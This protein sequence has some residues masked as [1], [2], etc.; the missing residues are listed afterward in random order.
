VPETSYFHQHA[1]RDLDT[2]I[3]AGF[4]AL[5]DD[6]AASAVYTQLLTLA[7]ERSTLLR[8]IR[9]RELRNGAALALQNLARHHQQFLAPPDTWPGGVGSVHELVHSLAQHLLARYPVPALLASAWL[10]DGADGH[11]AQRWFVAHAAGRRFRDI[12]DMPLQLTRRMEHILLTSPPHLPLRAALRRAE[13]LGLDAPPALV[14]T[15]L[16]SELAQD[17]GE[18]EF[19]RSALHFFIHHWEA[20][21]PEQVHTIVDFLYAVRIRS[22]QVA[23]RDG[24]ISQPPPQPGF[25]LAGRTPQSLNRLVDAWHQALGRGRATGRSWA[26]SGMSGLHYVDTP[27]AGNAPAFWQIDELLHSGELVAEGRVLRH[28]VASYERRCLYGTSSI[29]SLRR[30]VEDAPP[31]SLLTIEVHPQTR[32]IVQIRGYRNQRA[33]DHPRQILAL[34]ARQERLT[35]A[36]PA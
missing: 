25:S 11:E 27:E 8:P 21:G 5:S 18:G 30:Q 35:I 15:V 17:L 20:L 29:W 36:E 24:M 13:L 23:T 1:R 31:R 28:C 14:D 7:R 6:P 12:E 34:W 4:L 32:T 2:A 16:R 26:P 19:W 22:A 10:E 33:S 9:H 3:R